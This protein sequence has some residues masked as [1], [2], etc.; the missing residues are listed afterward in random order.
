ASI[1]AAAQS[2]IRY[3]TEVGALDDEETREA[4]EK[5]CLVP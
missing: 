1:A 3:F 2:C 4:F 5:A